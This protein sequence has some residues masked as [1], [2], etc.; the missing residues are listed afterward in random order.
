MGNVQLPDGLERIGIECFWEGGI[1]ELILPESVREIGAGA[2]RCCGKLETVQLNEGLEKLGAIEIISEET[3]QG[4]VFYESAIE[5]ITLPSTLKRLEPETF[6]RCRDLRKVV[7]PN[8]VEYIGEECFTHSGI[9]E[10][11]LPGTMRE[12]GSDAF[13]DC[14]QLRLVW[15]EDGCTADI[16]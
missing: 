12:I 8:G 5:E 16:G 3:Y 1:E 4:N 14:E 11:T 7:I 10:I 15:V 13:E 9:N 6:K 2:F